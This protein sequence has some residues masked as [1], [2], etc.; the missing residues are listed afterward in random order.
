MLRMCRGRSVKMVMRRLKA[1]NGGSGSRSVR[2]PFLDIAACI[3]QERRRERK[4]V[5]VE[6]EA[7]TSRGLA[8]CSGG[9][10]Q[11]FSF[12]GLSLL[13]FGVIME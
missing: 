13:S 7:G 1:L 3:Y 4:R 10:L 2:L 8:V 11:A 5:G 9:R 6:R 12:S